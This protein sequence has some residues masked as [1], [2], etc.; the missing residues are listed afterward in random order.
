M[1]WGTSELGWDE[2]LC[3]ATVTG[4][5]NSCLQRKIGRDGIGRSMLLEIRIFR[6]E[7]GLFYIF[8][9]AVCWCCAWITW[10][11][12]LCCG[13][14]QRGWLEM[15]FGALFIYPWICLRWILSL[16]KFKDLLLSP[17]NLHPQKSHFIRKQ[18][19]RWFRFIFIIFFNHCFVGPMLGGSLPCFFW[20][21]GYRLR[22]FA[23]PFLA[24]SG[25]KV[26]PTSRFPLSI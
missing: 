24:G 22:L 23:Y 21:R 3:I 18:T 11:M 5:D 19:A 16:C 10:F 2:E 7:L 14:L 8:I 17:P 25:V 12:G 6:C 26:E 9:N 4:C 20:G 1:R 13:G 15:A